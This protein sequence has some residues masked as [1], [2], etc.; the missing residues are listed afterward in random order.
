MQTLYCI[1]VDKLNLSLT[2]D[3]HVQTNRDQHL[4]LGRVLM[5]SR[6]IRVIEAQRKCPHLFVDHPVPVDGSCL[7]HCIQ[8]GRVGHRRHNRGRFDW[9]GSR[10]RGSGSGVRLTGLLAPELVISAIED[11]LHLVSEQQRDCA[12]GYMLGVAHVNLEQC[13]ICQETRMELQQESHQL[14][15]FIIGQISSCQAWILFVESSSE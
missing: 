11:V 4:G 6:G 10:G 14:L 7:G 8:V 2:F 15:S 1:F 9:L 12:G 5:N 3:V 13:E